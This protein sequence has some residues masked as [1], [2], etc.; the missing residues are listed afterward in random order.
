LYPRVRFAT[1]ACLI[2][3][4]GIVGIG[5]PMLFF[6]TLERPLA[7]NAEAR[8]ATPA[9]AER[10]VAKRRAVEREVVERWVA[11][12]AVAER[13]VAERSTSS[14]GTLELPPAAA[15]APEQPSAETQHTAAAAAEPVQQNELTAPEQATPM[16]PPTAEGAH[17]A[18][19]AEG[20]QV[21]RPARKTKAHLAAP[22]KTARRDR[23]AKRPTNEA[24][25]SM[26]RFGDTLRDIPANAYAADR[27]QRTVV[28]RP[29]S[30]QDVYYYSVPR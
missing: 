8:R 19:P 11:E 17:V 18:I 3:F 21:A 20:A 25:N 22:K 15:N 27:T 2:A 7:A 23:A 16:Q 1:C 29:T 14:A 26:R 13:A 30:I 9:L 28:I 10:E 5:A 12:R 4:L 24:L 6:R